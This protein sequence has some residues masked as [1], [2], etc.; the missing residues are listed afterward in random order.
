M[1]LG[2]S[3]LL[4]VSTVPVLADCKPEQTQ[5]PRVIGGQTY[6]IYIPRSAN[7]NTALK[8]MPLVY[9]PCSQNWVFGL[10]VAVEYTRSFNGK[11]IAQTL[12][13]NP[14]NM[15]FEG[16]YTTASQN[17]D[18][19]NFALVADYFGLNTLAQGGISFN[20]R[21]ENVNLHVQSYA[22]F[23]CWVEG[24]YS[25]VNFTFSH[26]KR[27]L[28]AG[29][30]CEDTAV[31]GTQD[32]QFPAGYMSLHAAPSASDIKTVLGGEFTFGDMQTPWKY[33]KFKFGSMHKNAVAG[34]DVILGYD[35]WRT[36]AGSLG[37]YLQ[38]TAPTGNKPCSEYVFSPVVG[39]GKHH[40][41]GMGL[42]ASCK[43]WE[44]DCDESLYAYFDGHVT[45]L[46]KNHQ[47][48]S[49]DFIYKGLN[50]AFSGTMSRYMLLK[51]LTPNN[52][53]T[54]FDYAGHLINAINFTTRDVSVRVPVKGDATLRFVYTR[55]CFDVGFGYNLYGH[56]H[57]KIGCLDKFACNSD[58]AGKFYGLKGATGLYYFDYI[59]TG[60]AY[61]QATPFAF[62]SNATASSSSILGNSPGGAAVDSAVYAG[63]PGLKAVDWSSAVD[64]DVVTS[65]G[66]LAEADSLLG[67]ITPD[68]ANAYP[69]AYYSNPA[70]ALTTADLDKE[71]AKSPAQLTHKGFVTMNYTWK[72]CKWEPYFGI[73]AEVEGGHQV[74]LK[75]WGVWVKG[76]F[77][78]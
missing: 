7:S 25:Q 33:G 42:R 61:I 18:R 49:F 8:F 59:D 6:S 65:G 24:L 48:R 5:D 51:E 57:E 43:L 46:L 70:V 4:L 35:F 54:G 15:N 29:C 69:N 2:L 12:F 10:D 11:D 32:G 63:A 21:I 45:S 73:G 37:L 64:Q 34:V 26:Q 30:G 66:V 71:S 19:N 16:L 28:F 13:G 41:I 44:N 9:R 27:T 36:Y 68:N 20:P 53:S 77:S 76:G 50:S 22:G 56:S 74:D 58:V 47:L 78:F 1:Y 38:Y 40:E 31:T 23:D 3:V 17:F 52:V 62:A 67:I 75:Q 14:T 60:S 55:D 72:H 39:N